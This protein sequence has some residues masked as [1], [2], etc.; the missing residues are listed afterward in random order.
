MATLA[1]RFERQAPPAAEE[2]GL[3]LTYQRLML[4][5]LLFV[6]VTLVIVGRLAMLQIFSDRT[7]GAQLAAPILPEKK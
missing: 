7:G 3:A 2:Q 1:A 5:M 4:M 6:G